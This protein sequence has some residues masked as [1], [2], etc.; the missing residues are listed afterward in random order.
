MNHFISAFQRLIKP[1]FSQNLEKVLWGCLLL[2]GTGCSL[3]FRNRLASLPYQF[4]KEAI[5]LFIPTFLTA[6]FIY[7]AGRREQFSNRIL[8]L[9]LFLFLIQLLPFGSLLF[10][11]VQPNPQEDFERYVQYAQNMIDQGTLWGGDEIRFPDRGK[12]YI[13]QPG[14]RYFVAAELLIFGKL[15]RY[16]SIVNLMFFLIAFFYLVKFIPKIIEHK[17]L[18][19]LTSIFVMLTV[20]YATKNILM[21]LTEWL[22]IVLLVCCLW[23]YHSK[24]LF[25]TI[26]ILAF[27]PF[28]RQNLLP[29]V[30]VLLLL[31][32]F[33][34]QTKWK[35]YLLFTF[36]L[37]LPVYHNLYYA[38]E[39]RF[40]T[41]IFKWPFI[42]YS[43]NPSAASFDF[44]KL[45]NNL[46]HY[47]GFD[48]SK[49]P[50]FLEESFL[51]LLLFIGLYFYWGRFLQNRQLRFLYYVITAVTVLIPSL[52]LAT[53][54]Y[55]RFEFVNVY[56]VLAFFL[57]L[58]HIQTQQKTDE[59]LHQFY[60]KR[61]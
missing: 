37:L 28:I 15:Y 7:L 18:Q 33:Q 17:K 57:V 27:I 60:L 11:V 54:F 10:E 58:Y 16:V 61:K 24:K 1:H 29:P 6:I 47:V 39:F 42:K 25:P 56:F 51:F 35:L 14:Y 12:A 30:F 22:V 44:F 40:F 2:T 49:K 36:I 59:L 41:S 5:G 50:D 20:P 55:P 8:W 32:C 48:I 23:L 19:S 34:Q 13:T 26:I 43:I 46:L 45:L 3:L 4:G 21:G 9:S 31:L 53:D 52:L 38:G